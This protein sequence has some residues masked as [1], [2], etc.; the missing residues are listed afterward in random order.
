MAYQSASIYPDSDAGHTLNSQSSWSNARNGTT[1]GIVTTIA[2][3]NVYTT[4][5]SVRG[6]SVYGVARYFAAFDM[7]QGL[8]YGAAI[9]SATANIWYNSIAGADRLVKH[10]TTSSLSTTGTFDSCIYGSGDNDEEDMFSY[11]AQYTPIS[12][13]GYTSIAL[14]DQALTDIKAVSGTSASN[15]GMFC[16]AVIKETDYDFSAPTD[17]TSHKSTMNTD[18]YTGTGRDPK[19]IVMY[20]KPQPIWFG[21]TF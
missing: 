10:N 7:S 2:N 12:T 8:P 13:S 3:T 4:Y 20:E 15:S 21:A 14:N 19:I 18:A 5:S 17:G 16:L 6:S 9:M 1:S 11:S